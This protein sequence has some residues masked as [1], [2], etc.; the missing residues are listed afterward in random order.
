MDTATQRRLALLETEVATLRRQR[1]RRSDWRRRLPLALV[2]LLVALVPLG[3]AAAGFNDL[4]PGSPH[5][6]N[7]QAIADAGITKGCDPGVSYC[8]NGLVTRE[9]MASFLARTAGLGGNAPVVNAKTAQTADQA[10]NAQ[11]LGGQPANA[12]ALKSDIPSGGGGTSGNTEL[13]YSPFGARVYSQSSSQVTEVPY[14]EGGP[15]GA[16]GPY[17][18]ARVAVSDFGDAYVELPLTTASLVAGGAANLKS[19]T[20][21]FSFNPFPGIQI[22]RIQLVTNQSGAPVVILSDP[23]PRGQTPSGCYTVAA[24]NGTA[25]N[26][27]ATLQ[28]RIRS[29]NFDTDSAY[30]RLFAVKLMVGP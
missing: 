21:C 7:I 28:F 11:Q 18:E 26:G 29:A 30:L 2:A 6:A 13:W 19:L 12:Y 25:I 24:P 17:A 9:E 14:R 1:A 27:A 5:N 16:T 20:T 10:T 23:T 15:P 4:N 22:N 8:P 3:I